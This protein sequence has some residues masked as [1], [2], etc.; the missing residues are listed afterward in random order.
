MQDHD[1]I[2]SEM[3]ALLRS[4][5]PLISEDT[6]SQHLVTTYGISNTY[7]FIA[8]CDYPLL[9]R[10]ISVRAGFF[11]HEAIRLLNSQKYDSCISIASGFSLLTFL[12]KKNVN[13]KIMFL[14]SDLKKIIVERESRISSNKLLSKTNLSNIENY[15]LDVIQLEQSGASLKEV[16]SRFRRPLFII[17]GLS[18]FLSKNTIYW[19]LK[20]IS[21]IPSSSLIFD[22][23][24]SEAKD[25]SECLKNILFNIPGF[26]CNGSAMLEHSGREIKLLKNRFSNI[27]IQDISDVENILKR[28][29]NDNLLLVDKSQFVPTNIIVAEP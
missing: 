7:N 21:C 6:I 28:G 1:F 17:E 16:F 14:D 4:A 20:E 13:N 22:Y 5:Y 9:A 23:C 3:T 15:I 12:I 8:K 24:P 27:Q 18:Y 19:L 2:S 25:K 10:V 29:K 26:L 11:L